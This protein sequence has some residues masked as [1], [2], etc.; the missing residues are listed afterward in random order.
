MCDVLDKVEN[1]GIAKGKAE[2]EDTLAL[3]R[4]KLFDQNRIEDAKRASEDKEY[5][6][7]LMKEFGI[8]SAAAGLVIIQNDWRQTVIASAFRIW[9][10]RASFLIG[11]LGSGLFS[12]SASLNRPSCSS[13]GFV[14]SLDG[15][16]CFLRSRSSSSGSASPLLSVATE[17]SP[18]LHA[19]IGGYEQTWPPR[20][21]CIAIAILTAFARTACPLFLA[22]RQNFSLKFVQFSTDAK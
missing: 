8:V 18:S 22:E 10:P 4:K 9:Q 11:S 3:V 14:C 20:C 6:T 15:P 2:G 19:C 17:N 13:V 16:N 5:R 21:R 12:C 7:R 1:R